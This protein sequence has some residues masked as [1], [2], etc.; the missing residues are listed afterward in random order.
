MEMIMSMTS[1]RNDKRV[2]ILV[3]RPFLYDG[4]IQQPGRE[5]EVEYIFYCEMKAAGRAVLAE[6]KTGKAMPEAGAKMAK[7]TAQKE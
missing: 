7:K 1:K 2:E 3:L 6:E 5:I 4:K